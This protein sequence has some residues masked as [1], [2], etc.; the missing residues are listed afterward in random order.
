AR[1]F[2]ESTNRPASPT[3]TPTS[4]PAAPSTAVSQLVDLGSPLLWFVITGVALIVWG[5]V[6]GLIVAAV[7][8]VGIF[9]FLRYRSKRR[10]HAHSDTTCASTLDVLHHERLS[11]QYEPAK[12]A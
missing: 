8:A 4:Q 12:H 7:S 9:M 11:Q 10:H 1:E 6:V 5:E 2:S 3:P